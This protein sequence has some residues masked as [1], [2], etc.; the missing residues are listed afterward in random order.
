MLLHEN[1]DLFNNL[2]I[3]TAAFKHI[4]QNAVIKDYMICSIL[5]KL[6][7]SE[8]VNKCIFKG[9]T[10]LSKCYEGAIDRFSED[11]DLTYLP[12]ADESTKSIERNLK[13]IEKDLILLS[14]TYLVL[15]YLDIMPI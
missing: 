9:G 11:I 6:S 2:V 4:P 7:K 10:S 12:Q 5:Q 15:K 3:Q 8:Y 14:L 13:N 1:E